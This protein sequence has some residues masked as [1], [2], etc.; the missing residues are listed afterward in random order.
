MRYFFILLAFFLFLGCSSKENVLKDESVLKKNE[1]VIHDLVT[2]PQNVDYYTKSLDDNV[3]FY[4]IQKN[5]EVSYFRIW[6]I[7]KPIESVEDIKWPF[8][9]YANQKTFG[10][11]LQP[12]QKF[13][14]DEMYEN[15]NF[16]AFATL[17]K[18][19]ITLKDSDLRSFP[20][21]RPLLK[22]PSLAGEGFPFDYLQNSA[23]YANEPIF[24]SHYSKDR[25]WVYVFSSFASGWIKSDRL[26]FLEKK[27]TDIWQKSQQIFLTKEGVPI[28]STDGAFLYKSRIGMSF[29]LVDEDKDNY[30]VLSIMAY[31]NSEPFYKRAKISKEIATKK[32]YNLNKENLNKIIGEVS[33]SNY[34]WGGMYG[35]RDCSS[36]LR[37][38]FAPF[39]IWLP[40]N[41]SQQSKVGK[42]ISLKDLTDNEKIALIKEKGLPFQTLLHK[43]GHIVLYVGTYNDEI[44]IFHNTWG[45]KTINNGEEG[46]VIVGKTV[47]STL[48]LGKELE[49]YD[50]NAEMLKKITSM[51]IL[52]QKD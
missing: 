39:G 19:A 7:E 50:P 29:A 51:N 5:Y 30:I 21:I 15:S 36:S 33:K 35:Q 52:T 13:F 49:S 8:Y 42:N 37:D 16:D 44:I 12:L 1:I 40:R 18:R 27:Y 43:K 3:S 11:N 4:E 23:I 38:I 28:L 2:I 22:D 45:I 47:F 20:T 9:A 17:N 14:F 26:V 24:A 46:R 32:I 31:K 25:E 34:G 48:R 6:N 10:E 41:S